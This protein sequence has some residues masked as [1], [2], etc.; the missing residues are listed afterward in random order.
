MTAFSLSGAIVAL[1]LCL[2]PARAFGETGKVSPHFF[3]ADASVNVLADSDDLLREAGLA[4]GYGRFLGH[5][6]F[7]VVD[8][9]YWYGVAEAP[10]VN[11]FVRHRVPL[12]LQLGVLSE[13][14][15]AVAL[16][17][18]PSLYYSAR[19]SVDWG[20]KRVH[21]GGRA[22]LNLAFTGRRDFGGSGSTC[23]GAKV[24]AA[25]F[26][27]K[28]SNDDV[29]KLLPTSLQFFV[30]HAAGQSHIGAALAWVVFR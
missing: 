16:R 11:Q 2:A 26:G 24:G 7:A 20:P 1:A 23:H 13:S 15:Y 3:A 25:C 9:G 14:G 30:E 22:A 28:T 29:L 12:R 6:L 18:E 4:L 10:D 27:M 8:L 5:R 19:K 17:L 21:V